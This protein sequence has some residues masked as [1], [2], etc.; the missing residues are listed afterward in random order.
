MHKNG[1]QI[2]K[3]KGEIKENIRIAS[4]ITHVSI[5]IPIFCRILFFFV[6]LMLKSTSYQRTKCFSV[7]ATIS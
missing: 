3:N 5:S 2:T 7:F 6:S 1:Y 4:F